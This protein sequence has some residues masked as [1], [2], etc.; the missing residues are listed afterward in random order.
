[1]PTGSGAIV[2][3]RMLER[4]L[5]NFHV[6]PYAP[7]LTYFPPALRWLV[8]QPDADIVHTTPD[9]A[10]MFRRKGTPLVVTFHNFVVDRFMSEY[11]TLAQR[12]HYATDLKYFLRRSLDIADCVTAVSNS[13]ADL[14]RTELS[15]SGHIE[16]IPNG[17]DTDAFR[18][19]EE[20]GGG[21]RPRV[22]FSGN[23]SYRKGAQWLPGI[24]ERLRG[25]ATIVCTVPKNSPWTSTF[26]SAG[27]EV[28]GKVPFSAMP[29]FYRS[30]DALL[31]PTV[32][33]GDCLAVLEA[34]S[35]GLP[36]VASNCSSLP[37]RIDP[38]KGG[39][40][41]EIGDIDGFADAVKRLA[42][43]ALRTSMGL[44]NRERAV[45]EFGLAEMARRYARVFNQVATRGSCC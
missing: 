37:E 45:S 35:S 14:V 17:V 20:P 26:R 43:P 25:E 4:L 18:P 28:V 2:V 6:V 13:T 40:L 34:M 10:P 39:Y 22:L 27:I 5:D 19:A 42:D 24:A 1:M 3:H 7:G 29:D 16:V 33:E 44:Y 36:V 31:L 23:P 21:E 8:P 9:H 15:F 38:G 41:C 32:R 30:V 12:L 11:S